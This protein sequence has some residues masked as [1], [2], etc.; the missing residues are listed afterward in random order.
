VDVA[1]MPAGDAVAAGAAG[2]GSNIMVPL[3]GCS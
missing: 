3:L 1:A 2:A